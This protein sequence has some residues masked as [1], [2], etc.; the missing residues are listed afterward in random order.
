[1]EAQ[2][3]T[4]PYPHTPTWEHNVTVDDLKARIEA[5]ARREEFSLDAIPYRKSGRDPYV[6]IL[7]AGRLDSKVCFFA[8]DLG[9]NAVVEGEPLIGDA[10]P[11]VRT[12]H[13]RAILHTAP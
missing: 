3:T 8:R 7:F 13:H 11:R 10:S 6:P 5:E 12:A 4:L 9:W 2:P 1:M